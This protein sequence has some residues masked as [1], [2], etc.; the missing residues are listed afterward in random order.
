MWR[1]PWECQSALGRPLL[2]VSECKE[3]HKADLLGSG[4]AVLYSEPEKQVISR[5]GDECVVAL[6]D[7]WY[8]NY[9]EP[10]WLA[11]VRCRPPAFPPLLLARSPL[12]CYPWLSYSS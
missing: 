12:S 8:L 6:T 3:K 1:G 4:E 5:S 7:Q 9:G 11:I 2:Q 10:S